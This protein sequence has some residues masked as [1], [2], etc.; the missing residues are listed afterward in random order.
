MRP[1]KTAWSI[2]VKSIEREFAATRLAVDYLN[3]Q[4]K[5]G[6][7]QVQGTIKQPDI[8]NATNH[9]EQTYLV[10]LFSCF[11]SILK[12]YLDLQNLTPKR[13]TAK[14]MIRL[15]SRRSQISKD[16]NILKSVQDL[17][18]YRNSIV[19]NLQLRKELISVPEARRRVNLFIDRLR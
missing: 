8:D 14:C 5:A 6:T 15:A 2:E 10:R 12:K 16:D 7:Y 3:Q 13:S 11:E 4:V 1:K 9:L 19:H 17:R 18:E